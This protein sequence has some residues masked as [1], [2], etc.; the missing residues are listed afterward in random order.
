M[1]LYSNLNSKILT[2]LILFLLHKTSS[3]NIDTNA[4]REIKPY[5][6]T[7]TSDFG[8]SIS[9]LDKQVF[10]GSPKT[11]EN[12]TSY[13]CTKSS[14]RSDLS[15]FPIPLPPTEEYTYRSNNIYQKN[16]FHN[17]KLWR[18]NNFR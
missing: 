9:V 17:Q 8:Y 18:F 2:K 4:A 3:F 5:L 6:N 1:F 14:R 11:G 7:D 16:S 13:R 10:I 12:G 15:C